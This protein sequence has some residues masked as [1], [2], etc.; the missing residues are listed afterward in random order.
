MY[1]CD[2]K[3]VSTKESQNV[4]TNFMSLFKPTTKD[5]PGSKMSMNEG[6]APKNGRFAF[7]FIHLEPK[8]KLEVK[9]AGESIWEN[10]RIG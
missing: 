3:K 10:A 2:L 5:M 4:Q 9:E 7:V 6:S 8:E 1:V